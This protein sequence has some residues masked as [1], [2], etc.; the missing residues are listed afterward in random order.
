MKNH[1]RDIYIPIKCA[2]FGEGDILNYTQDKIPLFKSLET[3]FFAEVDS[4][5]AVFDKNYF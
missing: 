2:K 5:I 4:E 3:W 1:D